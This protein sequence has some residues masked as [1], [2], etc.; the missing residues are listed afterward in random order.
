MRVCVSCVCVCMRVCVSCVCA[1]VCVCMCV[2]VCVRVCVCGVFSCACVHV[3]MRVC[4]HLNVLLCLTV[5]MCAHMYVYVFQGQGVGSCG[6]G[7]GGGGLGGKRGDWSL[8]MCAVCMQLVQRR[9]YFEF[10]DCDK[11]QLCNYVVTR[12]HLNFLCIL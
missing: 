12:F 8:R 5:H 3:F 11:R 4:V 6:G 1:R 10:V 9:Q 2:H 7:G